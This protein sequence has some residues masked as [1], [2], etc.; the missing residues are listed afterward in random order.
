MTTTAKTSRRGPRRALTGDEILEAA[1]SLLD[2]GGPAA[3]SIRGIA[4]KVG[5]APN[6]VYTYFPDKAAVVQAVVEHLLGQVNHAI[7]ADENLPWTQRI[8]HLALDLRERLSAHPGAVSLMIGGPMDGAN[9]LALNERLM[10]ILVDSGLHPPDAARASYLLIVYVFGSIALEVAELGEARQARPEAD[11]I[12]ERRAGF[13]AIP[14]GR[15]PLSAAAASTMA[16]YVSTEQYVWGLHRVLAGIGGPPNPAG[17][18][19]HR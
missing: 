10:E 15:Y 5:V 12:S 2:E 7:A 19:P 11:R 8:E 17:P 4:A 14:A 18:P 9:A 6:A 16:A 13:S 1:L 3:A